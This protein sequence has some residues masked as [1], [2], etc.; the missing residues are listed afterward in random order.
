MPIPVLPWVPQPKNEIL[1]SKIF[2]LNI[3]VIKQRA[4]NAKK[5]Y[6]ALQTVIFPSSPSTQVPTS[7]C[8]LLEKR[9]D[10][11]VNKTA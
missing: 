4:M 2:H 6:T 8:N 5:V 10:S 1:V 3:P 9:I 11:P 7:V